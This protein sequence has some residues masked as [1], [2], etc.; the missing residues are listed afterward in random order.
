MK[1]IHKCEVTRGNYK[2]HFNSDGQQLHQYQQSD[3][4]LSPQI[5]EHKKT[6]TYD[7]DNKDCWLGQDKTCGGDKPVNGSPIPPLH[8][9]IINDNTD[10]NTR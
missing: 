5:I 7:V 4:K 3:N 8:N 9:W 1:Q 6:I 2:K 10:R